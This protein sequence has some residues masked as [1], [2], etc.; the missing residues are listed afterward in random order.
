M[1]WVLI[2]SVIYGSNVSVTMEEF[3][4]Y[5]ACNLAGQS[6]SQR[7]AGKLEVLWECT[8]KAYDDRFGE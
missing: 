4:D 1:K 5:E 7:A 2:L 8:P 6:F 3:A